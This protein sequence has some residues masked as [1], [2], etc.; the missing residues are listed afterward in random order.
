MH[1]AG[2]SAPDLAGFL[3]DCNVLYFETIAS[4]K[5]GAFICA[6]KMR[7]SNLSYLVLLPLYYTHICMYVMYANSTR[8][9]YLCIKNGYFSADESVVCIGKE[10][11]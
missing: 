4:R 11:V 2:N 8:I 5:F 7:S 9:N 3:Q 6:K 1:L 10:L